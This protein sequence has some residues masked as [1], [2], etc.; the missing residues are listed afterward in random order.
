MWLVIGLNSHERK[1]NMGKY[2]RDITKGKVWRAWRGLFEWSRSTWRLL[3]PTQQAKK[4]WL[5]KKNDKL[6]LHHISGQIQCRILIPNRYLDMRFEDRLWHSSN[7]NLKTR[8][9]EYES[10][11]IV[12]KTTEK[13]NR[14]RQANSSWPEQQGWSLRGWGGR[15]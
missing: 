7:R 4:N 2:M 14:K 6:S 3:G 1:A 15:F 5:I 9:C 8:W 10:N 13:W 12:L 11:H